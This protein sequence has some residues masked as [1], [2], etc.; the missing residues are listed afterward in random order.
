MERLHMQASIALM[1]A[2]GNQLVETIG[3]PGGALYRIDVPR[4]SGPGTNP[5]W[6]LTEARAI[7]DSRDYSVVELSVS[8]S[9][10]KSPYS[11]SYKRLRHLVGATLPADA[12]VV[13]PRPDEVVVT[14]E[15][16][17]VPTHDIV[18]LALRE[19]SQSK[20]PR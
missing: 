16:S 17:S 6:D 13:P 2:S 20:Q 8:G 10:L 3:G 5:V 15:G 1:Q 11:L 19:L 14:G 7:I 9:F 12:F 18:V 4:V